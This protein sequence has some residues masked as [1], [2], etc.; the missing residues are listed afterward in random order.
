MKT[1]VAY[2]LSKSGEPLMPM[3]SH[4]RVRKFLNEKKAKVKTRVPYVIQ[5]TYELENPITEPVILGPDPGRT[6]IGLCAI[7]NKGE[8]L[9][10]ATVETRNKDIPDLMRERKAHR[11]ASRSG[12]RKRRQ[13][14]AVAQGTCFRE[15]ETRERKLPQCEEPITVHHIKNTEAKFFNRK[16]PEGWLTPTANQLLQTHLNAIQMV[17]KILPISAVVLEINA[18]DFV[19]ME[20][21]GVKNWEYQKGALHGFKSVEDAVSKRQNGHCLFCKKPIAHYHHSIPKSKGGSESVDNRC[22]LCEEHHHLVHTSAEWEAKLHEKQAGVL[23]KYHALSVINQIMPTLI[24]TLAEAEEN[25]YVTTGYDTAATRRAFDLP[26]LHHMDAWCITTSILDVAEGPKWLVPYSIQQFRRQ[27]RA[28]INNQRERT[29]KLD[30]KVVAKNR[31]KRTEQKDDALA[32]WYE[33]Q[34]VEVGPKKALE[35]LKLIKVTPSTRYK[36]NM[37]RFLPGTVFLYKNK[38]YVLSANHCGGQY[39]NAVGCGRTDYPAKKCKVVST[40]QGLVYI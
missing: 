35:L 20:N 27:N 26:K 5:L 10:S 36:N 11:Q 15:G 18:F 3:Y 9:Y 16:R 29:Y 14:R 7:N 38:R 23:K 6:N 1:V 17:K 32:D 22:G 21:P 28:I 24:K 25:F 30:G 13:R 12:E 19:K 2:V 33:K 4:K 39:F 40:N 37:D 31:R 8:V 34:I